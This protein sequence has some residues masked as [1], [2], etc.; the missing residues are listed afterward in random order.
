MIAGKRA[1]LSCVDFLINFYPTFTPNIKPNA[2]DKNNKNSLKNNLII[3]HSPPKQLSPSYQLK[4]EEHELLH[5]F[6]SHK[7]LLFF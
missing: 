3:F 2:N 6:F 7:F 4:Y 1:L 5:R